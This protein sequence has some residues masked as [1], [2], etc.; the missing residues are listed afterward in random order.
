[1]T[2]RGRVLGI[3]YGRVR[4]GLAVSDPE[5]KIAFPLTTYVRQTRERDGQYFRETIEREAIGLTVLGLPVHTDGSESQ[6]AHEV[7][8]FAAWF[9][10]ATGLSP[11]YWDE[12]FTTVEAEAHL[13]AAGLT[14]KTKG[15]LANP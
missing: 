15:E 10:E 4:I 6:K 12:R 1:M 2:Q 5:R 3:D 13:W 11:V 8:L 14:N 9:Q 7:R